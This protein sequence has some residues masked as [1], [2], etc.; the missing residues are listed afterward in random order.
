[1]PLI[2]SGLE[3]NAWEEVRRGLGR[4]APQLPLAAEYE[5]S[6]QLPLYVSQVDRSGFSSLERA[7]KVRQEGWRHVVYQ[8]GE[9]R[10]LLDLDL[11]KKMARRIEGRSAERFANALAALGPPL[12]SEGVASQV[13]YEIRVLDLPEVNAEALWL[14]R[15]PRS[16][17]E[18]WFVAISN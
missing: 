10:V 3:E 12:G 1:M 7:G 9:G 4:L 11:G 15:V 5:V 17:S 14:C 18:D 6:I 16:P 8:G 2:F 13:T